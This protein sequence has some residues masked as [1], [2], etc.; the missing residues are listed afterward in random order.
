MY[1]LLLNVEKFPEI[2]FTW[3]IRFGIFFF[4]GLTLTTYILPYISFLGCWIHQGMLVC[5]PSLIMT[6]Q[7]P[8]PYQY[9]QGNKQD[10][11]PSL[12]GGPNFPVHGIIHRLDSTLFKS[13]V[14]TVT[15]T[16]PSKTRWNMTR[17]SQVGKR[18][19]CAIEK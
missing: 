9:R 5:D 15:P 6:L 13:N 2:S 1:R 10:W 17:K 8:N 4:W 3:A 12:A 18:L 14:T 7:I 16:V 19:S 11:K